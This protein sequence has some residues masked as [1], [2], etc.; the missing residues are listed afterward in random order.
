MTYLAV[1]FAV[2]AALLSI[3]TTS[4]T[5]QKHATGSG[6]LRIAWTA[7]NSRLEIIGIGF[8][9][10]SPASVKVGDEPW[11]SLHAD[12]N[13][14]VRIEAPV[15][16][17]AAGK[18]GASVIIDGRAPSGASRKLFA[19]VPPKASSRGLIELMPWY[20]GIV[21]TGVV[22]AGAIGRRQKRS[23]DAEAVTK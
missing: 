2:G 11:I 22:V 4:S 9:G 15:T 17:A 7:D 23:A 19:A 6:D 21:L 16:T 20:A 10:K 3:P 12:E 5:P 14:T 18:P 13:G 1:A 8:R